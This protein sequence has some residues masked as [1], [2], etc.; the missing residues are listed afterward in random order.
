VTHRLGEVFRIADRYTVFRDG[1]HVAEGAMAEVTR[2][3]LIHHIVGGPCPR[4]SSRRT[5]PGTE[6]T[7]TVQGLTRARLLRD[8]SFTARRGEILGLYGLM[9]AGRTEILES[10]FGLAPDLTGGTVIIEGREV[11]ARNP[12]EAIAQGLALV[13]ED[14]KGSGLVLARACA[15]TSP[16]RTCRGC[17]TARP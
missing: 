6:T 17:R 15:P 12:R 10:L 13:T 16:W 14:R 1:A 3:G 9:G 8:V 5:S 4:S 11:R 7:L 2:E